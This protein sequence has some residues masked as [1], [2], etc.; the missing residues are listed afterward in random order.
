MKAEKI[1]GAGDFKEAMKVF[2]NG[3][4]D[5]IELHDYILQEGIEGVELDSGEQRRFVEL[6]GHYWRRTKGIRVKP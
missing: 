6:P 5:E 4:E 1:Q 2:V 3:F